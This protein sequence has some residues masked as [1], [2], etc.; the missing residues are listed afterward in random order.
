MA[1]FVDGGARWLA[2]A[3]GIILFAIT[4]LTVVSIAG[5]SLIWAG[6]GPILGDYEII[7]AMTG[8][9]VFCFLPYC[10]LHRGH[11]IL[12]IFTRL[13]GPTVVRLVDALAEIVMMLVLAFIAW[14]LTYGFIDKFHNGEMS[15]IRQF[16]I[17]W[18]Y[19]A[20][21]PAAYFSVLTALHTS[22]RAARSFLTGRDLL[23]DHQG[24]E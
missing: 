24:I 9:A 7:E 21:L 2:I 6:L 12:D 1:R 20:S 13:M 11:V 19:A 22:W 3:G 15:F 23:P 4:L 10:Q 5:R 17:W 14:R 8:V 18:G 16:P